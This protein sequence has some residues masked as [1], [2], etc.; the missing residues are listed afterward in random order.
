MPYVRIFIDES[1]TFATSA[2]PTGMCL[3]GALIFPDGHAAKIE[4]KYQALRTSFP[5]EKNE[6]KG[7]LLSEGEVDRVVSLLAKNDALFE[8]VGIEMAAHSAQGVDAHKRGQGRGLTA[9]VTDA[10]HPS[11]KEGLWDLR[12]RLES[13][14]RQL[15]VQS[16]ATFE[17]IAIAIEHSSL[18]FSQRQ[19]NTLEKFHWTIDSKDRG[20]ITDW[21]AWWS[22]TVMPITQARFL[23]D[24][25]KQLVDGDY[26]Y[27]SRFDI[28]I[29]DYLREHLNDKRERTGLNATKL[30]TESFRFSDQA[31][32]GLEMVDVLTNATRRA[33][34]GRLGFAGWRNIPRL[35][36]HRRQHYIKLI[37]L[38]QAP[39][40]HHYPYGRVLRHFSRGGKNMLAPRFSREP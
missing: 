8:V 27:F 7:R 38:E 34:T 11:V 26:S 16:V 29:P 10:F 14:S 28:P 32:P 18:Y 4:R 12:R 15:Y 40:A 17:L 37:S 2:G 1:G 24:P 33:L 36:I 19:P 9:N 22:Y 31:E 5:R 20:R 21:E 39:S 13:M 25:L 23:R 35:M 30:L 6:V 3:V